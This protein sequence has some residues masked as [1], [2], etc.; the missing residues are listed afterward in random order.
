MNKVIVS[1]LLMVMTAVSAFSQELGQQQGSQS[2]QAVGMSSVIN[3]LTMVS[4]NFVYDE[5]KMVAIPSTNI[6][7]QPPEYFQYSDSLPGFLHVGTM[8]SIQVQEVVGTSYLLIS[9]AMDSAYFASQG[10]TLISSEPVVMHDGSEG[11]LFTAEMKLKGFVFERL[12]LMS[13][14]YH[15]TIWI[16]AG[17]IKLMRDKL[18]PI[19]LQS[20]LTSKI[21]E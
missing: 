10:M 7:I 19:I 16:N 6:R 13:G 4:D 12:I 2:S 18:R 5:S 21:Y 11:V 1:V 17:Y 14:D 15:F 20:M 8:S 9:M 3:G